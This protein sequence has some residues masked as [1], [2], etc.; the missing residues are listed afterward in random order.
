MDYHFIVTGEMWD[1]TTDLD[2]NQEPLETWNWMIFTYSSKPFIPAQK[3]YA[4][5]I[6]LHYYY[7]HMLW[8]GVQLT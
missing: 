5:D 3:S 1:Q 2:E 8:W 7:T 6:S 4:D